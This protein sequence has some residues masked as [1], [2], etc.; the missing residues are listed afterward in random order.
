[1]KMHNLTKHLPQGSIFITFI[2]ECCLHH[3]S[4][5]NDKDDEKM[6]SGHLFYAPSEKAFYFFSTFVVPFDLP[7][8][9]YREEYSLHI[10]TAIGDFNPQKLSMDEAN[11]VLETRYCWGVDE[12]VDECTL[13]DIWF[14]NDLSQLKHT[15]TIVL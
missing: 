7:S 12:S 10:T 1:M 13:E 8:H 2:D 9:D 14:V 6:V 3:D 5:Y 4:S 11:S 15:K